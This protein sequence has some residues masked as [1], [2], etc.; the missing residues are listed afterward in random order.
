MI[1]VD[2]KICSII[3]IVILEISKQLENITSNVLAE[4][5]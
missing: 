1:K 4:E 5:E 3:K 2:S